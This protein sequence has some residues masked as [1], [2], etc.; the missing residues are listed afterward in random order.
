MFFEKCKKEEEAK[1]KLIAFLK[2]HYNMRKVE[3]INL[4]Y[5]GFATVILDIKY[6]K[7]WSGQIYTLEMRLGTITESECSNNFWEDLYKNI[8]EVTFL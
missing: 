4:K 3:Q 8:K 5:F 7:Y 2:R 1:K 6:K